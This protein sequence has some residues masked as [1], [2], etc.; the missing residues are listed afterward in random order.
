MNWRTE[1]EHKIWYE[2]Y[3]PS[4]L[5]DYIFSDDNDKIVFS[6]FIEEKEIPNLLLSGSAGVGKSSMV[7]ILMNE[8]SINKFD[9]KIMSGSTVGVDIVRNNIDNFC[10]V[11]SH[12]NSKYKVVVIEEADEMSNAAQ[13]AFRMV[14]DNNINN[15]RFI[16]TSNY[17][18]RII[19]ALHSR[20]QEV[21][22]TKLDY[23]DILERIVI[24]LD[25]EDITVNELDDVYTH[26][27]AYCPD[28][29]KIIN[30][31]QQFSATGTLKVIDDSVNGSD[32]LDDWDRL[33]SG[34]KVPM[35]DDALDIIRNSDLSN[36]VPYFTVMYEFIDGNSDGLVDDAIV[37]LAE[38]MNRVPSMA[39]QQLNLHA[40]ICDMY[41]DK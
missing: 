30:S 2:K 38:Y 26:I 7:H 8:L 13:K 34:D 28:M 35:K 10:K 31:I 37:I 1:M 32:G 4:G 18:E 40:C 11:L 24:I 15:T 36:P 21:N 20:V 9:V 5:D 6:K 33:W 17:P 29:R 41:D 12:N 22:I 16:F 3:K 39:C 19:P 27:D 14:M 23:N 25:A